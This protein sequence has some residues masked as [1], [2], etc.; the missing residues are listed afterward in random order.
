[1]SPTR[2]QII[3]AH[4]DGVDEPKLFVVVSH[5]GRNNSRFPTVLAVRITTTAKDPRPSIVEVPHGEPVTGRV[6]CDTIGEVWKDE[7][8]A[9]RGGLSP[10]TMQ[11]VDQGLAAA[12]ALTLA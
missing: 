2:G 12:L 3:Q 10:R 5:N 11:Q 8:L 6:L 1:V 4:I 9:V 7:I